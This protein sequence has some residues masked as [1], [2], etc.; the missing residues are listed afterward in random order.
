MQGV[1][2]NFTGN[3][4]I[5]NELVKGI[6]N[7]DQIAN[8]L[9]ANSFFVIVTVYMLFIFIRIIYWW[10]WLQS[11]NDKRCKC[12]DSTWDDD[13]SKSVNSRREKLR[14]TGLLNHPHPRAKPKRTKR[15]PAA[16]A[17]AVAV[18]DH[19]HYPFRDPSFCIH[20]PS[21]FVLSLSLPRT[22]THHTAGEQVLLSHT[23]RPTPPLP[24]KSS[25]G[26]ALNPD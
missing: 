5:L 3:N 21:P 22:Q 6:R 1:C 20:P 11:T 7:G 16:A 19:T 12:I 14:L 8:G 26:A 2:W 24:A 18:A 9:K 13:W 10:H 17:A 23:P 4:T 25:R 15:Q